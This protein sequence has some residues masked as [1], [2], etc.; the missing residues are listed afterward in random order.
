[1]KISPRGELRPD[2]TIANY[3]TVQH[4]GSRSV[5]RALE[6]YN[7]DAIISV[8]YRVSSGSHV[9]KFWI[10]QTGRDSCRRDGNEGRVVSAEVK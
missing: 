2:A 6:Y 7:L 5:Q 9:Q 1:M 4:E 10:Q 3:A 8:G